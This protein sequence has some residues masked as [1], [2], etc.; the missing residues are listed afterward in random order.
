M[1]CRSEAADLAWWAHLLE[2]DDMG[3]R[4]ENLYAFDCMGSQDPLLS[5]FT[6]LSIERRARLRVCNSY[7]VLRDLFSL[8]LSKHDRLY[9][10]SISMRTT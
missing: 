1:A 5:H 2:L 3:F 10:N 8:S 9:T 4:F 6:S 7:G